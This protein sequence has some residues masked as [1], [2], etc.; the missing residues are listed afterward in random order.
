MNNIINDDSALSP[1]HGPGNPAAGQGNDIRAVF[2]DID[3]TLTSFI[4]HKVPDSTVDAIHRLQAKGIKVLIC[5]GRAPSQ[6]GVVL[7]TMPVT[8]DGIAA[9]NGQYCFDGNGFFAAQA[10]E[11]DDIGVILGW[12]DRHPDVV[13]NFGEKDYVYFN[14]T[15]EALQATWAQLGKT[16]PTRYFDDPHERT[17][18]HET[19]Q[20]SPFIGP[21][22]EAELV[23]LCRNVRGV[24]WHPDFTDL[25]PA[26][27]GKPRGIQR[28]MAHYGITR[29]Q[30]MAFGDGGNDTSMLAYAGIGIAMGNATDEPK[31]AADYVTDD[32]DHD[33]VLNALLHFG[34]L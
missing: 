5:T 19:F 13:A 4:T 29:E 3:G 21:D 32:V 12:L 17:A 25:I 2:F 9:F 28:F 23:G 24:R 30:T 6:M 10:I 27:G 26:D 1:T 16:A 14:H 11:P 7:D 18:T 22:E 31:A 15:N 8:F 20:I 34:V 33:G